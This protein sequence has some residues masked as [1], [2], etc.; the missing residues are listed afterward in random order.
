MA[1]I[2]EFL[3]KTA[4]FLFLVL[5]SWVQKSPG[6][7]PGEEK[8]PWEFW[9]N[10][11][12]GQEN[13]IFAKACFRAVVAEWSP[14][15]KHQPHFLIAYLGFLGSVRCSVNPQVVGSSPTGGAKRRLLIS[16]IGSLFVCL[17]LRYLDKVLMCRNE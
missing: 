15:K 13:T 9:E 5:L 8:F 2:W 16:M 6:W 10:R 3:G 1:G 4:V 11:T 7:T 17:P 12:E 14:K